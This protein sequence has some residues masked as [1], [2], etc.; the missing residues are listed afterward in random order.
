[1]ARRA[2]RQFYRENVKLHK[3]QVITSE[4]QLAVI[5]GQRAVDEVRATIAVNTQQTPHRRQ[6]A[7][8]TGPLWLALMA[9]SQMARP[10]PFVLYCSSGSLEASSPYWVPHFQRQLFGS[11]GTARS[12]LRR[13]TF[14]TQSFPRTM[15]C[16]GAKARSPWGQQKVGTTAKNSDIPNLTNKLRNLEGTARLE[17]SRLGPVTL[18]CSTR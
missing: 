16:T 14:L 12:L 4:A 2:V 5:F 7:A 8:C 11:S 17:R 6:G 18:G 13:S 3:G 10:G 1:M 15:L 9:V